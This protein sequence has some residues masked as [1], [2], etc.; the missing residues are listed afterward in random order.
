MGR[1]HFNLRVVTYNVHRCRGMDRRVL[2]SRIAKILLT[3]KPDV[4]ALQEVVGK[5]AKQQGQDEYLRDR[6][7]MNG[8][9]AIA[10]FRRGLPLGNAIL[11]RFPI[12]SESSSN[13]TW[14][15]RWGRC[16][17]RIS[18]RMRTR[19]LHIYNAHLGT[20]LRERKFQAGLLRDFVKQQSATGPNII[21]GDFNEWGRGITRDILA[22]EFQRIDLHPFLKRRRS[23]PGL[24]PLLHLDHIFHTGSVSIKKIHIP[25]N[26]QT[27][28]AS[29]HVPLVADLT[30]HG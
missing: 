30:I 23:Y 7:G 24:L 10:R 19:L 2:P 4:I 1:R 8:V 15:N 29:D 11:T 6:L 14:R 17:Q 18:I 26:R 25:R 21:L 22:P 12:V 3:L 28:I 27:L 5:G 9:M 13:L 16:C 20:G